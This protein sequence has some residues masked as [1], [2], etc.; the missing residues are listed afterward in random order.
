MQ[1]FCEVW[2]TLAMYLYKHNRRSTYTPS[3]RSQAAGHLYPFSNV[4]LT[5]AASITPPRILPPPS[6]APAPA[7]FFSIKFPF[8]FACRGVIYVGTSDPRICNPLSLLFLLPILRQACCLICVKG[9]PVPGSKLD[10][11][12]GNPNQF[13]IGMCEAP[14]KNC[15]CESKLYVHIYRTYGTSACFLFL[16]VKYISA[17]S[18]RVFSSM[19]CRSQ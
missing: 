8:L 14:C 7:P 19:F 9:D 12:Y 4:Y 6:S 17:I 16:K 10:G 15:P 2:A 11:F 13:Q 5:I 3:E 18:W 1:A